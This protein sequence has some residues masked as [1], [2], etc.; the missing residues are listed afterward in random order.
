MITIVAKFDV[1]QDCVDKFIRLAAE[2]TRNTR[3]E[4]GN[5]SYKVFAERYDLSKFVFIEEWLNDVAIEKHNEMA[6]F[7]T[8]LTMIAPLINKEPEITQIM[9]VPAIR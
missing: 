3:K 5:L 1:K 6:H 2:C 7:N 4:N 8:F 9:N